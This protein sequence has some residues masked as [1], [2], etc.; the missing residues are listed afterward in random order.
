MYRDPKF[1]K[2]EAERIVGDQPWFDRPMRWAQLTLVENDPGRYDAAEWLDYFRRTHSDSACL[3]AGGCVAY[4]PTQVP[5]HHRS[6]F[7]GPEEDPLGELIAGCR[8]QDMIVVARTDPHAIHDEAAVAHP[9]WVA[10]G[11]DGTPR[12]H[13]AAADHWVTCAFGPH[14]ETFMTDVHREIMALYHIEGIFGNRWSGHGICYCDWCREHFGSATGRALPLSG[15]PADPSYRAWLQWREDRLFALWDLWDAAIREINPQARYIP[16]AGGGALSDLNMARTGARADILFADRQ[17]RSGRMPLWMAGKNAKE[18]RAALGNKPAGGIFSVG[19]EERYRWKDSVQAAPEIRGWVA[20]ATANGLRPWFTK[21][22]GVHHDRR[23]L[24]VVEHLYDWHYRHERYLR[25]T[26][27]LATVALVYS[28]NTARMVA[29]PEARS[30]AED[31]ALGMYQALVEARIPFDMLHEAHLDADHLAPYRA[32]ILPNIAALSDDAGD[33]L[34]AFVAHGGGLL[35]T[36]ETS[37]YGA[38][39]VRRDDLGLA[40]VF[41]A[42]CAG[43]VEGPMRNAYLHVAPGG[44]QR[45]PLLSGLEDAQ[46][47]IHGVH[48]LPTRAL[49]S[50]GHPLLTLVPSY[51]DLPMEQVY[52]RVERTDNPDVYA[53][54]HGSGRVVYFPWDIDRTYWEILNEDHGLL[55]RNAASWVA[56]ELPITVKGPGVLD[57]TLWQQEH[58]V[59][60]HLVNLTNPRAQQGPIREIYSVGEQQIRLMLPP[61]ARL[62]RVHLLCDGEQPGPVTVKDGWLETSVPRVHEYQ[63]LAVELA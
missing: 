15:D 3:S 40:D 19:V 27:S 48:R 22:G 30:R 14:A 6:T 12:R 45:H 31:P 13:W 35:A 56:G 29:G 39:G 53:R 55:L 61:G 8:A 41:S 20:E 43:A 33:A 10:V 59:T 28:Q 50:A 62:D 44:A 37:L 7:M 2:M 60:V 46:R 9:E 36:H 1:F 23:W 38:G 58:S 16:N 26:A 4:Y 57:V 52:P 17:A 25:N 11:A 24:P 32:L 18:Y 42:S 49:E 34:R 54:T 5:Y 47:I 63:V 51:P 21:F